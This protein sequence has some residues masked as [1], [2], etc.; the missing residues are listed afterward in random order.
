MCREEKMRG[1]KSGDKGVV[2]ARRFLEAG[3]DLAQ[4][5][6]DFLARR[7]RDEIHTWMDQK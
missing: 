3:E 1:S 2:F 5:F 6:P 4:G 7:R